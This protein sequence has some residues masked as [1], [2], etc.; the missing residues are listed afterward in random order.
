MTASVRARVRERLAERVDDRGV[1][2]VRD[3]RAFP[4]RFTPTT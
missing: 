3:V 1:A 2:G 4:T